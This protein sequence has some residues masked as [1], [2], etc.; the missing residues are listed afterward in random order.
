MDMRH[1]RQGADTGPLIHFGDFLH[2]SQFGE[3]GDG[4]LGIVAGHAILLHNWLDFGGPI[5]S[6]GLVS[7]PLDQGESLL[8]RGHGFHRAVEHGFQLG[9]GTVAIIAVNDV[10]DRNPR[11]AVGFA[12][13]QHDLH[14][15]HHQTHADHQQKAR[16]QNFV[17][18]RKSGQGGS[19]INVNHIVLLV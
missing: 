19:G 11:F 9:T 12:V 6:G 13:G 18:D 8:V 2:I 3:V 5:F 17:S 16:E 4:G 10:I 14:A 15:R 1:S 7:R